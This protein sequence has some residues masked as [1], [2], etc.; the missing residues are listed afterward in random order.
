MCSD[1]EFSWPLYG[2]PRIHGYRQPTVF[3]LPV[4]YKELE[5]PWILISE[6]VLTPTPS[7]Y[8]G[9]TAYHT[10]SHSISQNKSMTKPKVME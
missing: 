10:C 1:V 3:I 2:G 4:L 8:K 7:G 6:G 5:H 9:M